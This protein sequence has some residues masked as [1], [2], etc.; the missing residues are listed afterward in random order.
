M[1]ARAWPWHYPETAVQPSWAGPRTTATLG[2]HG[3]SPALAMF[4]G[5]KATNWWEAVPRGEPAKARLWLCPPTVIPPFWAGL[6]THLIDRDLSELAT[7][8]P[9]GC[10]PAPK[11]FGCRKARN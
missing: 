3:F 8:A 2:L 7:P 11:A 5:N 4:G 10:S 9:H 1:R 6:M